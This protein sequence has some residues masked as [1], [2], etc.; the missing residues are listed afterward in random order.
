V[1]GRLLALAWIAAVPVRAVALLLEAAVSLLVLG[2]AATV[3]A[4]WSGRIPDEA[5]AE[6]LVP[7]GERLLAI[8]MAA[9]GI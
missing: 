9:G 5:V 8:G 2:I 1:P 7:L 3:W 4:W 6:F